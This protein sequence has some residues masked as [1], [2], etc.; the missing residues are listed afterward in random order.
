MHATIHVLY[1]TFLA[2]YCTFK[3]FLYK[4]LNKMYLHLASVFIKKGARSGPLP[5]HHRFGH[6]TAYTVCLLLGLI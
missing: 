3:Q 5:H 4:V 1:L 6:S 2:D